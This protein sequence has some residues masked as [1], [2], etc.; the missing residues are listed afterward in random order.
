MRRSHQPQR[1]SRSN[2][3][4]PLFDRTQ[5]HSFVPTTSG[6]AI[7]RCARQGRS[8]TGAR[9]LSLMRA[10]T[11]ARWRK[12]GNAAFLA[13]T[14]LT[15]ICGCSLTTI[16]QAKTQ[17]RHPHDQ[18]FSDRIASYVTEAEK[19]FSIPASWIYAV[20][21]VES[22]GVRHAISP[23]GAMGLMQLMPKTWHDLQARYHLGTD[24]FEPH[25]NILAGAAYLR[26]MHD[27]YG[28]P[29]DLAAYNA[30]PER[31]E[32]YRDHRRP[33]PPETRA[34][35]A[36]LAPF[37]GAQ[38]LPDKR[39]EDPLT[40]FFATAASLFAGHAQVQS[41]VAQMTVPVQSRSPSRRSPVTDMTAIA[42]RSTGLFVR[43]SSREQAP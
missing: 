33:L 4:I 14:I 40:Q 7:A 27:R 20:M 1:H 36:K 38:P 24:P 42:P 43:L 25:D 11:V 3:S 30:G 10:S 28:S 15:V 39:P 9:A 19:R 31:Y 8:Q 32:D 26:E 16:A 18:S 12:I 23:K 29:G 35:V 21:R 5:H 2:S 17:A 13:A 22:Q 6:R 34:Y 41:S 37:V